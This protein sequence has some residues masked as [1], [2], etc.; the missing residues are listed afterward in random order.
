MR[1][2][3]QALHH[4]VGVK[5]LDERHDQLGRIHPVILHRNQHHCDHNAGGDLKPQL[6]P[7]RK[8]Q[9]PLMRHFDVIVGKANGRKCAGGKHRDPYEAIAQ[10]RHNK[11]GTTTAIAISN[12]PIVG[13]PAFF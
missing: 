6:R 10:V 2:T 9:V 8:S 1:K 12:P 13:V 7:S 3:F 5:L 4:Q 11:V